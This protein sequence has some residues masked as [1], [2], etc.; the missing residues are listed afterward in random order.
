MMRRSPCC[1]NE[2]LN[3]RAWTEKED[4]ILSEYIQIHG[5]GCWKKLPQKAGESQG[6]SYIDLF[7]QP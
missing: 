7:I 4:M 6:I 2:G 1:S 3:R 5:D